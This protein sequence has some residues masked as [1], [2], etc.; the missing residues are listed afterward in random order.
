MMA[1][2]ASSSLK[3]GRFIF[4]WPPVSLQGCWL[5]C[6][7]LK[8][9][10]LSDTDATDEEVDAEL[11]SLSKPIIWWEQRWLGWGHPYLLLSLVSV[12]ASLWHL[13]SLL[14]SWMSTYL[15]TSHHSSATGIFGGHGDKS[16]LQ[17]LNGIEVGGI[18][19]GWLGPLGSMCPS[20][21][22][23]AISHWP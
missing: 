9:S 21:M 5:Q 22:A 8:P 12:S 6:G 20:V 15:G 2:L 11:L 17:K 10:D 23:W 19:Q 13:T 1:S 3:T 16:W 18:E 14:M 4:I 7:C